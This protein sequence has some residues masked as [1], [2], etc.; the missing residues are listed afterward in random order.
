M[1]N[2]QRI[3]IQILLVVAVLGLAA[4][5]AKGLMSL[6]KPPEKKERKVSI[7]LLNAEQVSVQ[8]RVMTVEGFGT[9]G[10]R[11]EIQVVPQVSGRIVKCHPQ[12][13][14][15]GFFK[16]DE[17]LA[18]I[19][20]TD[21]KLAVES[22]AAAVAQSK[23]QLEME[24]AE[25]EVSRNEWKN[26]HPDKEPDSAL[27]FR[28]PQIQSA[29]AQ[30]SAAQAQLAKA[31]LD[32]ERTRIAMPFDG[33]VVMTNVD[34]GQFVTAGAPIATVYRTDLVEVSV[35]LEDAEL[36]W[37]DAPLESNHTDNPRH[38]TA[39][40][41]RASFAGK[42]H[43]WEG[44]IVRTEGQIDAR[45]RMVHVVV[46]VDDPFDVRDN[47]IPLVPGMFVRVEIQG[48]EVA[49][50]IRIPRYAVRD[51]KYV[52]IA[53]KAADSDLMHLKIVPVDIIR[54]DK[55][56]AYI[57]AGLNSGDVVVTS[58]LETV[59]DGML[60][61]VVTEIEADARKEGL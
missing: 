29:Q 18:V 41:L 44:Q 23:V 45:S 53:V 39:A 38:L 46:Q 48:R 14:N 47:G 59:T 37:F 2:R 3:I 10:P 56:D 40:V 13:V 57:Q 58:P 42:E 33:R 36:A 61:R 26:L 27:V 30:L 28:G 22:A 19:E 15:G 6:R 16:A 9:V 54:M 32:L 8:T 43:S 7:P 25:A 17:A 31:K 24:T 34:A 35:P 51:G 21:Y 11:M 12:L 52:W 55:N 5:I 49:D 60:I 1:N 20:Q 4:G 50:I